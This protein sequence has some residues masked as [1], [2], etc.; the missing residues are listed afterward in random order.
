MMDQR[1]AD[2]PGCLVLLIR[3]SADMSAD[4]VTERG[5]LPAS[6]ATRFL[7]DELV[8]GL[9]NTLAEGY[10]VGELDVALL[11][12]RTGADGSPLLISLLPDGDPKPRF[13]SLATV[14]EMPAEPRAA[15]TQPRKWTVPPPCESEPCATAALANVYQ[16]VAMWLTGRHVSR[17]PVVIHCTGTEG[18]D[19]AYFRIARSIALLS[20]G[21]GPARLLHYAF[22]ASNDEV[23]HLRL[24]EVS[25]ELPENPESGKLARRGFFLNNWD[26]TDSWDALFTF[27]WHDDGATWANAGTALRAGKAMWTQKMGNSPDQWEDAFAIDQAKG[28][29]AVADGAS[30]GIYCRI[31]ADQLSTRYLSDRPDTRDPAILNKWVGELRRE[32]RD[33]INYDNLNW[34][35]QAKVDQT[36]A[37]ATL[38]GLELGSPQESGTRA[39]RACAVG[40]ACLF[41]L[42]GGRLLASFPVVAA[43]QFGSAP[44]LVRSNP[45]FKT[46]TLHA[47]GDCEPADRFVLATDAVAARLLKSVAEGLGPDWERFEQITEDE[48]RAE[49][50]SLRSANEMVNDDCTLVVLRVLAPSEGLAECPLD[51]EHEHGEA[52]PGEQPATPLELDRTDGDS[53]ALNGEP[54]AERASLLDSEV[55][56]VQS[57]TEQES[58]CESPT[59]ELTSSP[60]VDGQGADTPRLP[61]DQ[62]EQPARDGFPE[63]TDTRD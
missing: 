10:A 58:I 54:E 59:P 29:A 52:N 28:A 32:W 45:G 42:R 55:A 21:N 33:A 19:E 8:E 34:S 61:E 50:D 4:V 43:N 7:A 41:W 20:T 15:E 63:S 2:P 48:W 38:L 9:V 60:E 62:C 14:A 49:L 1:A 37:A 56:E 3:L 47:V 51:R 27:A 5:E 44:L 18:L 31:W 16:M 30:S 24:L 13:F 11:G 12:Y 17:P 6:V 35:K 22:D 53:S 26:I 40:D 46:L 57:A 25:S 36:G 39:W 23:C